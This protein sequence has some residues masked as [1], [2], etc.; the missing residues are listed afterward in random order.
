MGFSWNYSWK[1]YNYGER[2]EPETWVHCLLKLIFFLAQEQSEK[3]AWIWTL[4]VPPLWLRDLGVAPACAAI[5]CCNSPIVLVLS[6]TAYVDIWLL[7]WWWHWW[8]LWGVI[9]INLNRIELVLREFINLFPILGSNLKGTSMTQ[10]RVLIRHSSSNAMILG[11]QLPG[12]WQEDFSCLCI[13][14]AVLWKFV[15]AIWTY[16]DN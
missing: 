5:P 13:R 1:L 11:F 14:Q 8:G 2:D 10:Q 9:S 4:T 15:I 16:S 3:L 12:L 7:G 6:T